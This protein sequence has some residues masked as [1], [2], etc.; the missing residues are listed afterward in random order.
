MKVSL[1]SVSYKGNLVFILA[2]T[3]LFTDVISVSIRMPVETAVAVTPTVADGREAEV[4]EKEGSLDKYNLKPDELEVDSSEGGLTELDDSWDYI[5]AIIPDQEELDSPKDNRAEG[6][7]KEQGATLWGSLNT[8]EANIPE[9]ENLIADEEDSLALLN[10]LVK[11]AVEENYGASEPEAEALSK[12]EES[13]PE[14]QTIDEDDFSFSDLPKIF[15]PLI[16][17]FSG[18]P[19][20]EP[21]PP[22]DFFSW[23]PSLKELLDDPKE[24]PASVTSSPRNSVMQPETFGLPTPSEPSLQ[25][26]PAL[27]SAQ[28]DESD[29][30][31]SEEELITS[32]VPTLPIPPSNE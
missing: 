16:K 19:E 13:E 29:E 6:D 24:E 31:S 21:P 32:I 3:L 30:S 18:S 1:G 15:E 26:A 25:I 7:N 28:P 17:A 22:E 9:F 23:F 5:G 12:D 8:S 4:L 11:R 20:S 27:P 10:L 2:V 14:A